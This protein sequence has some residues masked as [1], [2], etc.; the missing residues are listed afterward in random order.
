MKTEENE[1]GIPAARYLH[2]R[3]PRAF[4]TGYWVVLVVLSL[5]VGAG[6]GWAIHY[7][8]QGPAQT[9]L[10]VIFTFTP[11]PAPSAVVRPSP[12]LLTPVCGQCGWDSP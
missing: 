1:P 2:W 4:T 11:D 8:T 10:P 5:A 6:G 12:F 7:A 3:W 9:P